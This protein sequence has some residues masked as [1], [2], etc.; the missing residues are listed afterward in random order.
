MNILQYF[1]DISFLIVIMV[2]KKKPGGFS[3]TQNMFYE[4]INVDCQANLFLFW[5]N[6]I[7]KGFKA[8]FL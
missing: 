5:E 2:L 3:I 6:F 4:I 1:Y 7:Y 8:Q